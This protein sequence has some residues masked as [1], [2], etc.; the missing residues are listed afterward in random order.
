MKKSVTFIFAIIIVLFLMLFF[1]REKVNNHSDEVLSDSLRLLE[2]EVSVSGMFCNGCAQS[3]EQKLIELDGVR[4]AVASFPDSN[5]IVSFDTTKVNND[6]LTH[7]V[8][9][10]GYKVREIKS[11]L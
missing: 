3:I 8:E 5:V 11:I 7:A 2:V 4:T 6:S 1:F 9:S 10:K